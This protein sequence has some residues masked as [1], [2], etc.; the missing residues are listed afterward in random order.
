MR[1]FTTALGSGIAPRSAGQKPACS[2]R[3]ISSPGWYC[4]KPAW[5]TRYARSRWSRSVHGVNFVARERSTAWHA[6]PT[7]GAPPG[8]SRTNEFDPDDEVGG[9]DR[10]GAPGIRVEGGVADD[11]DALDGLPGGVREEVG[12]GAGPTARHASSRGLP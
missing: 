7:V 2:R 6:V 5:G 9:V 8:S 11:R 1:A 3:P 10:G 12:R 4:T